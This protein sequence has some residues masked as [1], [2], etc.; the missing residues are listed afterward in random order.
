MTVEVVDQS[1]ILVD[2]VESTAPQVDVTIAPVEV[3]E[4]TTAVSNPKNAGMFVE[5]GLGPNGDG[6]TIWFEDE[7]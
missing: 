2:V 1:P 5:T 6:W 4:V 7:A 3:V